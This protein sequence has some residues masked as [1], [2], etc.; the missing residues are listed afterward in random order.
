MSS[1]F[2]LGVDIGGSHIT[3]ALVDV[4]KRILVPDSIHRKLIDS[5]D[6]STNIL[7]AWSEVINQSFKNYPVLKKEIGIAM[8]GPFD[9]KNG[10]C[11]IKEQDKF[12]SL[13]RCNIKVELAKRLAISTSTI[14]FINDA[15][16][17]LQGEVFAGGAKGAARVLGFT[18]GT[19]LGSSICIHG[20]AR[21]AALWKAPFL[22][23]MAEDYLS[24]KWFVY[25][26]HQ[27][28]GNRLSG[29]KE[30]A[31][32]VALNGYAKQVFKE[33]GENFAK[34]IMPL[35]EQHQAEVIILGGNITQAFSIFAPNLIH[36]LRQNKFN[37]NIEA[38]TL[39]EHAT[40]IGAA[41]CCQIV[42]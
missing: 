2:V 21:D 7:D 8:P 14:H 1:P 26:Y 33:F 30:L 16:A 15:A 10:I 19:G 6:K 4:D 39:N 12:L 17:F 9:Y 22:G 24:T 25:R 32:L 40:L 23:G 38:T 31:A 13:Y 18:L 29:V 27:L 34:F 20:K 3:T 11:L 28:T 35:I 5:K 36:I 41:S 37:T 42:S